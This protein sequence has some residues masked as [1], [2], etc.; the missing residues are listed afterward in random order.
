MWAYYRGKGT[1]LAISTLHVRA[2]ESL[3]IS[4]ATLPSFELGSSYSQQLQASGSSE[5]PL[6]WEFYPPVKG[7]EQVCAGCKN[8]KRIGAFSMHTD[9]GLITRN[10]FGYCGGS[11][12]PTSFIARA[13]DDNGHSG[14]REY[15]IDS[16]HGL[17]CP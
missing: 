6:T 13:R 9:S 2:N 1:Y 15:M 10:D 5:G 7:P 3:S 12:A 4:P 17:T 8:E 11:S 14:M 16:T